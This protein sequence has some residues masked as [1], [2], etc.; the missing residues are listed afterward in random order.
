VNYDFNTCPDRADTGSLKWERY[1]GRHILPMWVAD[2]DFTSAPEIIEALRDRVAHGV[3]GYTVPPA[4]T[5]ET[6]IEYLR[7]RHG[8]EATPEQILWFPG[9]VPALNVACR[10]FVPEG[11]AAL[12]CTPAYPPFLTAP[13]FAGAKLQTVDLVEN[14]GVWEIDFEGL[15]AAVTPVTKLFILCNPH[16]PTG[17]VFPPAT[18]ERLAEFCRRH[19]LV[20][21][22]DEIHCDLVLDDTPH[23]SGL[24][25]SNHDGPPILSMFAPSKTF[26]LAG[27]ACAFVVVPDATTRRTFQKAARGL[28]TEINALGYAGCEAAFRHG[29][30]WHVQLLEVLRANRNRVEDFVASSLPGIRTWHLEATYLAWLDARKLGLPN[31]AMFF[32]DHGVGL[33]DGVPFGAP[34]G[35][36]RLNFGC[37]RSQL[38]EALARMALAVASR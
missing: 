16:N 32:E 38:D 19:G 13:D 34:Q 12:T 3:F 24:K 14:N 28:I 17:R 30:P 4:S 23:T 36:L 18:L 2:M 25:L 35:F 37:P 5:V 8:T 7:A 15:E 10:A 27:L 22:S 29:W 1:A 26:N 20:L 11:G 6:A 31:A 33:S 21:I 9:L